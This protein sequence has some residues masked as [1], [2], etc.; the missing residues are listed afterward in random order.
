M[1]T[2]T[3]KQIFCISEALRIRKQSKERLAFTNRDNKNYKWYQE[4]IKFIESIEAVLSSI[5][6]EVLASNDFT[7]SIEVKL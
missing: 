5:T 4:D 1:Q 2:L 3:T 6:S 7:T